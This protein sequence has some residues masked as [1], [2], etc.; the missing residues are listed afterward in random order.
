MQKDAPEDYKLFFAAFGR[1][2]K[3]GLH[4]D[5]EN[6]DKIKGLVMFQSANTTKGLSSNDANETNSFISLKD[7]VAAMP[8][9]QKDIYYLISDDIKTA[10]QSPHIEAIISRGFDVLFLV[11]PVDA[12][13]IDRLAEFDGKKL[14]AVDKG[15]LELGSDEEKS[16][17]KKKLETAATEYK[18]LTDF[19]K[20][21]LKDDIAE[22][23]LSPRLTDS[24]C[25]LVASD[26][27]LNASMERLMRAMNQTI[28][29]QQRILELNPNH[30]LIKKMNAMFAEDAK[31]PSL[32]DYADLLLGQAQLAEGSSPKDPQ[33]FNRLI[34]EL[35]TKI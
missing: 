31:N 15:D 22:V 34:T 14:V 16:E 30:A 17:T 19:I 18:S 10:R 3:E 8:E 21:H 35:M 9:A 20:E 24:A 4:F 13:I 23:K 6:G 12:Y 26:H 11:D 5:W 29:K 2:L 27:A 1:I 33:R 28:S 7:Y 25:C 32:A